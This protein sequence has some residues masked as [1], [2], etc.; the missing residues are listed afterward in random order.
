MSFQVIDPIVIDFETYYNSKTSCSVKSDIKKGWVG[1]PWH[2]THHKDFYPYMLSWYNPSTK[3]KG[4]VSVT[5][6]GAT[7]DLAAFIDCNL[8]GRTIIAHNAGFEHAIIKYLL[9]EFEI[10]NMVDTADLSI[11]FQAG[12]HLDTAAQFLLGKTISKEIRNAMDGVHYL[13]LNSK[14]KEKLEEYALSDAVTEGEIFEKCF[15]LW[16]EV[17]RWISDW[18]R[19]R[20]WDGLHI[21][22]N[23]LQ[24][25]VDIVSRVRCTAIE[26][27]PW[28]E[29]D[30]DA[31]LSAKKLGLWCREQGIEPPASLAE[32]S[33]ECAEW[34][35]KY[36]NTYPVVA[37]MRD[38]RKSNTLL[39]K[40]NRIEKLI[41]PDGTMPLDTLYGAAPH[42]MRFSSRGVNVQNL[43]REA[44]LCDMRGIFI[45]PPG[46]K[47]VPS[48]LAGIEARC[49]PYLAGDEDYLKEVARLDSEALEGETGDLYE[50]HARRMFHYTEPTPLRK[51]DKELR[52]VT[53][54]CVLALGFQTGGKKFAKT[55]QDNMPEK[56]INR[57]KQEQ[58]TIPQI[59]AR[60]VALYRI[61]N[62]KIP[63]L[64]KQLNTELRVAAM[65]GITLQL[66][67]PSGRVINYYDLMIREKEGWVGG[68]IVGSVCRGEPAKKLYG[69]KLAENITQAMA[70]DVF[71]HAVYN[72]EH[73]GIRVCWGCHDEAVC[74]VPVERATQATC[75][76]VEGIMSIT[77]DWAPGLPLAAEA[78]VTDRYV[79]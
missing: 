3:E 79:K 57:I 37:A 16:P 7:E 63:D 35:N 58:E 50:P 14:Q 19:K 21:D 38:F 34:E 46:H 15:H 42:T 43:P 20:N 4:V 10:L 66:Q 28:V 67:L 60:L 25:Q 12:R 78:K 23:Y 48:D 49:L 70:R 53:K 1:G 17:E 65:A 40:L 56:I 73:R 18:N 52:H 69:G 22:Q 71:V 36:G 30:E 33:D 6:E 31:P 32:D 5:D 74:A 13:D 27:I 41:R 64:W 61:S 29:T 54:T 47:F 62:P 11:Y 76:E 44:D 77:P 45:P 75:R 55:V 39:K 72:L 68:E 26:Q 24:D 59:A 51:T 9:P 8:K 2:Y